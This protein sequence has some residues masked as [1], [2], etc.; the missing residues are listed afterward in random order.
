MCARGR[1]RTRLRH[2]EGGRRTRRLRFGGRHLG[3]RFCLGIRLGSGGKIQLY[4]LEK[5]IGETADI[6]GNHPGIVRRMEE[7]MREAVTP[8]P[9]YPVGVKYNG[10]PLWK[11]GKVAP[12]PQTDA[13]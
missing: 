1:N 11:R 9:R 7:I 4:D 10:K 8:S 6:A 13:S 12:S 3:H 2:C 5:D